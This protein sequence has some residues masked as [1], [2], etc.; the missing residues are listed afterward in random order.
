MYINHK[1]EGQENPFIVGFLCLIYIC[2]GNKLLH[3]HYT[4]N[5]KY[6]KEFHTHAELV[7]HRI[8]KQ[9]DNV[10]PELHG[11]DVMERNA[12]VVIDLK[13]KA[14]NVGGAKLNNNIRQVN[15][16]SGPV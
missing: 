7:G 9:R 8:R 5:F 16:G 12:F 13:S 11:C 4:G 3:A 1:T 6:S 2:F 10:E 14:V 15:Q